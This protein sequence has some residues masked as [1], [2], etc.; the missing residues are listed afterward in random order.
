VGVGVAGTGVEVGIEVGVSVEVGG[1]GVAV[2]VA[3]LGVGVEV[4][5]PALALTSQMM[6][7]IGD[8]PLYRLVKYRPSGKIPPSGANT[9]K[10][11]VPSPVKALI[12]SNKMLPELS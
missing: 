8:G 4:A 11:S 5:I 12:W 2:A 6:L 7:L 3:G 10:E 1:T 9:S